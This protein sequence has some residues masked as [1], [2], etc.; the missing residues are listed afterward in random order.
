MRNITKALLLP[1][2]IDKERPTKL[3]MNI[4]YTTTKQNELFNQFY[5]CLWWWWCWRKNCNATTILLWGP[6]KNEKTWR[7]NF[8][9]DKC[10]YYCDVCVQSINTCCKLKMHIQPNH[11]IKPYLFNFCEQLTKTTVKL[12]V[13]IMKKKMSVNQIQCDCLGKL[14]N[15][16][17]QLNVHIL[18]K[19]LS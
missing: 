8:P 2:M 1:M 5:L 3:C 17:Y 14:I 12:K 16:S 7:M 15:S 10:D 13:Y 9:C 18:T 4:Y 19:H 6:D 11:K